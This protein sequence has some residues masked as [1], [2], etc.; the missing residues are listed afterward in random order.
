[1]LYHH[2]RFL[3]TLYFRL[4]YRLFVY[5]PFP[6]LDGPLIE[7]EHLFSLFIC[8]IFGTLYCFSYCTYFGDQV[9]SMHEHVVSYAMSHV[10]EGRA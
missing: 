2:A 4:G 8:G 3:Y 5:T 9:G 10:V 6:L 7:S 1:M